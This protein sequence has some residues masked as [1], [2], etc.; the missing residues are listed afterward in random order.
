ME[1]RASFWKAGRTGGG[2]DEKA[3]GWPKNGR[4]MSGQL[5]RIAPNLRAKGVTVNWFRESGAR[6]IEIQAI[7]PRRAA[8]GDIPTDAKAREGVVVSTLSTGRVGG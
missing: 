1:L 5:K 3:N 7:A 4:A 8:I 6:R 2:E